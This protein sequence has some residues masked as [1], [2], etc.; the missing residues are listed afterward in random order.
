[1]TAKLF[2]PI[3]RGGI[4]LSNRIVKAP[5]TSNQANL[6]SDMPGVYSKTQTEAWKVVTNAVHEKAGRIFVQLWH[7]GCI[8]HTSLQPDGQSPVASSAIVADAKTFIGDGFGPVSKPRAL[9]TA[10]IPWLVNDF[11]I[12]LKSSLRP[13]WRVRREPYAP[14]NELDQV[15][16]RQ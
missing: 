7:V 9:E 13:V 15:E 3:Q 6:E 11:S 1:M 12:V 8:S 4:S 5:L 2:S 14:L 10:E 16:C